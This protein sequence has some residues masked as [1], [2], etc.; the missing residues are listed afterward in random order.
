MCQLPQPVVLF[1]T[2]SPASPPSSARALQN[3]GHCLKVISPNAPEFFA[4]T[5]GSQSVDPGFSFWIS[6]F[7]SLPTPQIATEHGIPPGSGFG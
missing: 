4:E 1:V 6:R 5:E 3:F 2:D 7:F